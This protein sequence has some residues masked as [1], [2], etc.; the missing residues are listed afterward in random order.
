MAR[1]ILSLDGQVMAEYNMNKERYTDRPSAGQR[2]PHRQSGGQRSSL[3]DHQHPQRLVPRRSE[4]HQRHVRQRQAD[5]EARASA[6]RRG[7]R[8]SSPAALRRHAERGRRAGRV[9]ED[10][11]HHAGLGS[12]CRRGE[13]SFRDCAAAA[14]AE[15]LGATATAIR[16]VPSEPERHRRASGRAAEGE[17][18]GA[19]RR[20]RGPRARAEQGTD[21]ARP[22]GRAGRGDHAPR[23]WLLHRA[24]RQRQAERLSA[25][26][27]QRR[28][29]SRRAS[30]RTTT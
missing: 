30:C 1:L 26:Q 20:V 16:A 4:Q 25:G 19:E 27:R 18:A 10:H 13:E 23:R 22:P 5:Q 9:R 14:G 29:A 6:R 17:A 3:A 15:S 11:G 21:D 12:R 28:S 8:R 24:R 2:H 7:H